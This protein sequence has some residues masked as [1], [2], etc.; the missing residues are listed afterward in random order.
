MVLLILIGAGGFFGLRYA[1]SALQPVDP[2]SKQYMSVQIPDGANTQEIG[3]VL[4][5][6]WCLLRTGL[7]FTLYAKYKNYTGLKSGYL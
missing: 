4:E 2:S 6:I 3:S 5:K 7:V 1:E